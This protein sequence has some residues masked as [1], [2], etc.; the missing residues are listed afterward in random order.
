MPRFHLGATLRVQMVV[1]FAFLT[2]FGSW[3][4][5]H[6][7]NFRVDRGPAS[8]PI[9]PPPEQKPGSRRTLEKYRAA[10]GLYP[11]P[12][13]ARA[14]ARASGCGSEVLIGT[15]R[16]SPSPRRS[17]VTERTLPAAPRIS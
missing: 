13:H 4:S 2:I 14:Q 1:L 11:D 12:R 8:Q 7:T 6:V 16:F 17:V 10:N 3:A 5:C 9:L 15:A